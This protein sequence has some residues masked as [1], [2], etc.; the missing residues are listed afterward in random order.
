MGLIVV[1]PYVNNGGYTKEGGILDLGQAV[2]TNVGIG[3]GWQRRG[4]RGLCRCRLGLIQHIHERVIDVQKD[5]IIAAI[6]GYQEANLATGPPLALLCP[7]APS[8][9]CPPSMAP[10]PYP[11]LHPSVLF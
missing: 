7:P 3:R 2:G 8:P 9:A 4:H 6:V 1:I 5:V 11:P 10:I